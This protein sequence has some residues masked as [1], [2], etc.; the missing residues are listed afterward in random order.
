MDVQV[1]QKWHMSIVA[2][3]ERGYMQVHCIHLFTLY[4][5][6]I[7]HNKKV[8]K[9]LFVIQFRRLNLSIRGFWWLP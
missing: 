8:L 5:F 7:L 6:E 9:L 3:T 4:T 1:K 2:E